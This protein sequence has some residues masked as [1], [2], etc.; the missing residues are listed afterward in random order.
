[1]NILEGFHIKGGPALKKLFDIANSGNINPYI[2]ETIP[3]SKCISAL[4]KVENR[5]VIGRLVLKP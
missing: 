2:H 3:L 1:M 4:K 5:E